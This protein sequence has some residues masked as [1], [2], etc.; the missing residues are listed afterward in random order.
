MFGFYL[1]TSMPV[2]KKGMDIHQGLQNVR[3]FNSENLNSL[4]AQLETSCVHRLHPP[5]ALLSQKQWLGEEQAYPWSLHRGAGY[6]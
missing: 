1:E 4:A 2:I 6:C 5:A 3:S